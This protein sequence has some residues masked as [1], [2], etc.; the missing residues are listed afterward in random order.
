G[1][2]A[3]DGRKGLRAKYQ[4]TI[5]ALGIA[6][7]RPGHT[8]PAFPVTRLPTC[9]WGETVMFPMLQR[10]LAPTLQLSAV[11][12]L[13]LSAQPAALQEKKITPPATLLKEVKYPKGYEATIFASP[14]EVNYPTCLACAPTGEVFVGVDQNGSLD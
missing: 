5:S 6:R 1:C 11:A 8:I 7:S 12:V 14:P 13:V 2:Q 4:P 10:C 3:I 9:F